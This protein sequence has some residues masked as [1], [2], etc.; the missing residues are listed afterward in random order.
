M[1]KEIREQGLDKFYTNLNVAEHCIFKTN[2]LF[3][4]ESFDT[5]VEPSAG[6]GSF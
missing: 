6:A 4:L 2:E 1:A 3:P 5:I